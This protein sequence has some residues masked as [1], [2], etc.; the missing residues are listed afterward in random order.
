MSKERK[1]KHFWHSEVFWEY[2]VP[3]IVS[4]IISTLTSAVAIALGL[5]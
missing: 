1:K 2:V 5:M 3:I 4:I